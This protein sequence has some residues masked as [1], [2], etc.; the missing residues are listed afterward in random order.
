[1]KRSELFFSFLLLPIDIAAILLAF[2][3]AY[4]LRMNVDV[5][6]AYSDVVLADYLQTAIYLL[7]IWLIFFALAGLYKPGR[8]QSLFNQL[9]KIFISS[10]A[11]IL[12]LIVYI[13][14]GK[15]SFFSRLI[16]IYT[17]ILSVGTVFL[18]R[19]LIESI[20]IFLYRYGVGIH[21]AICIGAN[22]ATSQIIY[23]SNSRPALGLK[24]V[25]VV[26]GV[27]NQHNSDLKIIGD[28]K[29]LPQLISDKKI[30]EVF[31][32]DMSVSEEKMNKVITICSDKNVAFK[33]IPNSLYLVTSHVSVREI[34]GLPVME[35]SATPLDGWGR[36]VK[37]GLDIL[38][39]FISLVL[40]SPLSLIAIL[41]NKTISP[42]PIFYSHDRVGRD[43]KTFRLYKFRSMRVDAETTGRFWTQK[44]DDRVTPFGKF[45]RKTNIDEIPQFY[46]VLK[47]DMSFV[48]PRPEQP[49]F[50]EKFQE[51]IPE[52][53]RRHR[54]K[55]GITGW[56]QV[57]GLKGDT[58]I[59]ERVRYDIYYIEN[60]SIGFEFK[61]I[62]MTIG[63][64][65]KEMFGGKYEY[66]NRS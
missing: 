35:V 2:F 46:N 10:S 3:L 60:W 16:L 4:N 28:L 61:I 48:G 27:S 31:L 56:A 39:A 19:L 30:D 64:V 62:L 26:N 59:K 24:I 57:N 49:K 54:V 13:F 11:A 65:I 6:P 8:Y 23:L 5:I 7:P 38:L 32:T 22:E 50:V 45:I 66:R 52:Y 37:R 20:K 12:L 63:L 15:V 53:F 43:G 33:F 47:G 41:G 25:G 51:E 40:S 14:L 29:D 42:G 55:S 18:G 21:R 58:S 1:M 9:Y 44:N 34:A 17:W 36:I